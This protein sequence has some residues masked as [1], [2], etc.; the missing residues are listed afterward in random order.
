MPV[1]CGRAACAWPSVNGSAEVRRERFCHSSSS[2][3]AGVGRRLFC[4]RVIDCSGA[5]STAVVGLPL[6]ARSSTTTDM[7][8]EAIKRLRV[9]RPETLVRVDRFL[10]ER[11]AAGDCLLGSC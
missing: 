8:P 6:S 4:V 2:D 3:S 10:R 9:A 5:A 11:H 1:K 7:A